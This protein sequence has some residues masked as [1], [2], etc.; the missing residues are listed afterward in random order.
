MSNHGNNETI[1]EY[2]ERLGMRR[3]TARSLVLSV[4]LGSDPPRLPVGALIDFCSLFDI[5]D[6][7]VR[8]ALSRMVASGEIDSAD[9]AYVLT[10]DLLQRRRQ[11]DVGRGATPYEWD[12][13]WWTAVALADARD[14]T[15]RR[16]F[17]SAME[18]AKMGELR[19]T[20]WMRP[21]NIGP[22]PARRDLIVS[23]GDLPPAVSNSLV[24]R[25]WRLEALDRRAGELLAV[26]QPDSDDLAKRFIALA[27]CL[28]YLRTEPQL[29]RALAD[30]RRADELRERY[31]PEEV[32]FQ[33]DLRTFLRVSTDAR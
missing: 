20:A 24:D 19:P 26:V 17:R 11:Q 23:R 3:F 5:A 16:Q 8:T 4:L 7:T 21:S 33:G 10:G 6:G 32:R 9:G 25:L 2:T 29:P 12:G 22:P 13:S 18:G 30:N 31:T 1:E 28:R 15:E 27:T 14:I